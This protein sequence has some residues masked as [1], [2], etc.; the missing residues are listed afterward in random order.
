MDDSNTNKQFR[1]YESSGKFM[2]IS[3]D[4]AIARGINKWQDWKCSAGV[5]GLYIDYDGNLWICNTASSNFNRFNKNGWIDLL[6]KEGKG[7]YEQWEGREELAV[8]YGKSPEA[9]IKEIS[10]SKIGDTT[11]P[12]FIGNINKGFELP[13]VWHNCPW[14][15]CSCGA[16]V[17]LSKST[18]NDNKKLLAV[19]NDEFHGRD[20]TRHNLIENVIDPV[21][22]EMNFPIKHQILWDLGRRCNY[23]CSYC[24]SYVHNRTDLHKDYELLVKTVDKLVAE[25]SHGET[26]RWNFGGGEPTLHPKFL[27]LLQHLKSKNQWTMVTTNGTR[28]HK[29]W[30][31]AVKH[32]N[33]IN[34]SAHFDGLRDGDDEDRFV[35]NIDVICQH[36]DEHNDDHWLEIK[37]MAPPQYISRALKLKDKI[38]N[39]GTLDKPGAN[40]RIKGVVSMVPIRSL[41]DSGTLVQYTDQQLE[42]FAKQ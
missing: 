1:V 14:S 7:I 40:N 31:Q 5:R 3:I 22:V 25:W 23:D 32:L 16:D 21:A 18:N 13:K 24:W 36:F 2:R 39:L 12:G 30:T 33:S 35:R 28:D 10:V 19:T 26:I 6:K 27:D 11:L 38:L 41:G 17:I 9:W 29:Y 20:I 4:E 42:I 34:L 8:Q 37:L 15:S